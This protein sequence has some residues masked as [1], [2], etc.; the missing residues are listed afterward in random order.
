MP[1]DERRHPRASP[2]PGRRR[3]PA[4]APSADRRPQGRRVGPSRGL[5]TSQAIRMG[6]KPSGIVPAISLAGAASRPAPADRGGRPG[7]IE[8]PDPERPKGA[9]AQVVGGAAA[10]AEE[11]RAHRRLPPPRGSAGRCRPRRPEVDR[12]SPGASRARPLADG[13][14]DHGDRSPPGRRQPGPA[15][16]AR[17][18]GIFVHGTTPKR[19]S[20]CAPRG[21]VT[22]IRDSVPCAER[23]RISAKPSPPSDSGHTS[24]R[25]P[26]ATEAPPRSRTPFGPRSSP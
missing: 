22:L 5:S 13:H 14:L 20:T 24:T 2:P 18:S 4:S 21:P 23:V 9:Q 16:S 12:A 3:P 26:L 8:V 11:D 1:A 10:D 17:R 6:G 7:R 19:A 25:Q 15:A